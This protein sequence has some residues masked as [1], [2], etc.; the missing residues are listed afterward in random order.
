VLTGSDKSPEVCNSVTGRTDK[1]RSG[2]VVEGLCK[3]RP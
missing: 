2:K 3:L 1:N